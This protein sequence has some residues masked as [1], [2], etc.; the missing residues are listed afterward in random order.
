MNQLVIIGN[1]FD[2]AHGMKTSY[3]DFIFWYLNKL[4][5][6]LLENQTYHDANLEMSI[7]ARFQ[8][9]KHF[10]ITTFAEFN[11][12]ISHMGNYKTK[13]IWNP[14]FKILLKS[15][16]KGWVD[17]ESFYYQ[18]LVQI[19]KMQKSPPIDRNIDKHLKE[20]NAFINCLK[21]NLVTY[22]NE[23]NEITI[24]R[25]KIISNNLET[26]I[27]ATD[28]INNVLFANFNYTNTVELYSNASMA[29]KIQTVHIHGNIKDTKNPI[30]FGY[31]D[32]VDEYYSKI[33]ETGNDLY[34]EN[35]KSYWYLKT[36]NYRRII[37]YLQAEHY[38][39]KIL[40][41]SCGLTDRVLLS[42]IFTHKNCAE[43]ELLYHDKGKGENDYQER[44]FAI[45][46][47]FPQ[48]L[49]GRMRY[50]IKSFDR[51]VPLIGNS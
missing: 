4:L 49:K 23:I 26:R 15:F 40:G 1:G 17:I 22:L 3:N 16:N 39:V 13:E 27:F 46:R 38:E 11:K 28:R 34:L 43:I 42:E 12:H 7:N 37:S 50:L 44:T 31:G 48:H 36:S 47:Q 30:I 21:D 9:R 14:Y 25:N 6:H 51:S 18:Q 32:E 33:E 41:H 8:D 24:S 2:L 35:I 45:G 20:L 29:G 5:N 19:Y 10:N